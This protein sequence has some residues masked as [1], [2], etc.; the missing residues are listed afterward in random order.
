MIKRL[1]V[2][3]I[4]VILTLLFVFDLLLPQSNNHRLKIYSG[5]EFE[6]IINNSLVYKGNNF[7]T[8]INSGKYLI[9][10]YLIKDEPKIFI[11]KQFVYLYSD[12]VIELNKIF[13]FR[14]KSN[15]EDA[16][17][18]IDSIFFG[19]SPLHLNLLFKPSLL[20]IEKI[21][22]NKKIFELSNF[23][24]YDFFVEFKQESQTIKKRYFDY[25]YLALTSTI[26]NGILSFYYKKQADKF[27][28]K[29]DKTQNDLNL[30]K[31]YDNYS[32]AFTI[33]M[34][35][36]FGIFVYLLFND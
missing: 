9:E 28:F 22:Y 15:P 36:S 1:F 21:G 30:V 14:V 18:Y 8:L 25:K 20:T 31:K 35:I 11:Y 27:Y 29:P 13:K 34:E 5:H 4:K 17:V 33:G 12:T 26:L 16:K 6:L 3:Q 23:E 24:N 7:D 2:F 10:A 32:A 19:Y